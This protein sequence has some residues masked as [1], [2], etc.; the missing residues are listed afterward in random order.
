MK[1]KNIE[2][3]EII[4]ELLSQNGQVKDRK[5]TE[6]G[7]PVLFLCGNFISLK[8]KTGLEKDH[9][10]III[11]CSRDIEVIDLD[12][13]EEILR[14]GNG[15][16]YDSNSLL[17]YGLTDRLEFLVFRS[18]DKQYEF[19]TVIERLEYGLTGESIKEKVK[20]VYYRAYLEYQKLMEKVIDDDLRIYT[21]VFERSKYSNLL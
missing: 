19:S 4:I 1:N 17:L 6:V 11:T 5:D 3:N 15:E 20:S 8:N 21:F 16:S 14:R 13:K 12:R 18:Q 9:L 2:D 10:R 7:S